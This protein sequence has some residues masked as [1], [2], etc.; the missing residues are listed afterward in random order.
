[1]TSGTER[2]RAPRSFVALPVTLAIG[3]PSDTATAPARVQDVSLSGVRC[4]TTRPIGV[5]TQVGLTLVIPGAPG[6]ELSGTGADASISCRGAVVRSRKL[7]AAPSE[8][9]PPGSDGPEPDAAAV[10]R[11][12]T[13]IFFTSMADAD[14]V[15]LQ[16]FLLTL[17][18]M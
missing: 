10:V 1:M 5:M 8:S 7:D 13:A 16:E 4:I 11:Y 12:E 15:A 14:R 6:A 17:N 2:R 18:E 9:D 3:D